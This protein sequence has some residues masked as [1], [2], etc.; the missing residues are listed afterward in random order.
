[1][2]ADDINELLAEH[3]LRLVVDRASS[4]H[5]AVRLLDRRDNEVGYVTTNA[6][7]PLGNAEC[8][9]NFDRLRRYTGAK[10]VDVTH[11]AHLVRPYRRKGLG[12][13]MYDAAVRD[14]AARKTALAPD[15]CHEG[16]TSE[17]AMRV[18]QQLQDEYPHEGLVV[19]GKPRT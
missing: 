15:V 1:M 11:A 18:W 9:R 10:W 16:T 7:D 19:W 13:V 8:A 4:T 2:D 12:Y 14:A 17:Q 5:G 3:D 6:A